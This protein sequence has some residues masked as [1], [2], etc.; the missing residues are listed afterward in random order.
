MMQSTVFSEKIY[1]FKTFMTYDFTYLQN[2]VL[3]TKKYEIEKWRGEKIEM[4]NHN[5]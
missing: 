4:K 5:E 3:P 1:Y 2:N